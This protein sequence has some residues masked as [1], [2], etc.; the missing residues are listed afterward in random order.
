V[1][2]ETVFTRPGLGKM[3]VDAIGA[4]DYPLAQGAITVFT[5]IINRG[6]SGR[7]PDVRGRRSADHLPLAES[8]GDSMAVVRRAIRSTWPVSGPPRSRGARLAAACAGGCRSA[9]GSPGDD[10]DRRGRGR[11][12][13][14]PLSPS[15]QFSDAVRRGRG[16]SIVICSAPTSFG[17]DLLS[18]IIWGAR[19]SLEVGLVSVAFA[20]ALGCHWAS[21][22]A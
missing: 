11:A 8:R 17:R 21:W 4:R 18:R 1:L 10:H 5:M 15:A 20:F 3:L 13:I 12:L 16:R 7:R 9:S 22:P 19:V 14:A 6:Q 2:T